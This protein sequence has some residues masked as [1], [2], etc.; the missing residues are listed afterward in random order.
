MGPP[1]TAVPVVVSTKVACSVVG[2]PG[3]STLTSAASVR[4]PESLGINAAMTVERVAPE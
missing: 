2:T 3:A 1:L 4:V